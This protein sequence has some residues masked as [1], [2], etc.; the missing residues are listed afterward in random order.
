MLI[1]LEQVL[2]DSM[3]QWSSGRDEHVTTIGKVKVRGVLMRY[4]HGE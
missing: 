4:T 2:K 1:T 3:E